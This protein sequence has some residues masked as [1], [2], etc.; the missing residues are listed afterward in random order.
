MQQQVFDS[1]DPELFNEHSSRWESQ[2]RSHI[3][4]QIK[5][6][7]LSC[8]LDDTLFTLDPSYI[9]TA[10]CALEQFHSQK[11]LFKKG[12]AWFLDFTDI[13]REMISDIESGEISI[14]PPTHT[15]RLL[16][17]LR[18]ERLWEI[19]REHQ[20]GWPLPILEHEDGTFRIGTEAS[21]HERLTPYLADTWLTSAL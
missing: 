2:Y 10:T 17:M 9:H 13:I 3:L 6:M 1:K 20:Y 5:E 15:N 16:S 18:E 8:D 19:S 12:G 14:T 21:P 7:G 11:R 4:N